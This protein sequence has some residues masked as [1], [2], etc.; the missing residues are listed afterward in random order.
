M[1]SSDLSTYAVS[2]LDALPVSGDPIDEADM[3]SGRCYLSI[4]EERILICVS[5]RLIEI[6]PCVR[7]QNE[8]K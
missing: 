4:K 1:F 6:A 2:A 3:D 5:Q 7:V 8:F